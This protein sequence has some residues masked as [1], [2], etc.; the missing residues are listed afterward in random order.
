MENQIKYISQLMKKVLIGPIGKK[1]ME[2]GKD[3]I[4]MA[5]SMGQQK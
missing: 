2:H 5:L 1:K 3:I 4:M